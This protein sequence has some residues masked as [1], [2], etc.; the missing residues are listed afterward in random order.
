MRDIC[1]YPRTTHV[2]GSRFQHGDGDLEAVP[3]EELRG[4][5]L[6][7]EEKIDGAN[8]GISFD[9]DGALLIQSRGHYL[10]G[11]PREEQFDL[12]KQW[13]STHQQ[14]LLGILGSRYVMYGE[15]MAA[16]HTCFYDALPHLFMEFDVLD[17]QRDAFL[18]TDARRDLLCHSTNVW[19]LVCPVHVLHEGQLD[20][21][22][23][24]QA[25]LTRSHF[26]TA[27]RRLN[28]QRA[29]AM[30]GVSFADALAHT[31][32]SDDA[33]GL[34]VKWEENGIV[35]G[36][37]KLV[38]STFTSVILNQEQHWHDR[39]IINNLVAPGVLDQMFR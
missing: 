3:W 29:S 36:R 5:H 9:V 26:I 18:S 33:E 16:K 4:K 24:L 2:Q 1:K 39:L 38:R 6:V 27:D 11:G 20:R 14:D 21:L 34:Y 17:T 19:S 13:A 22:S 30:A 25:L 28:L 7:V 37:Y 35:R 12:L 23:D 10:H 32:M 31:D 8:V 15:W